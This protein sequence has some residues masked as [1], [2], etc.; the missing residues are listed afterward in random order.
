M[1]R[2]F[3]IISLFSLSVLP[4]QTQKI[5]APVTI[6]GVVGIPRAISS[7]QFRTCFAGVY[8]A[9][10]SVNARLFRNFFVGLGYQNTGFRNAEMFKYELFNAKVPY[11]TQLMGHAPFLKLGYDQ[12]FEKTYVSYSLNTGFMLAGYTNVNNDTSAANRPFVSQKFSAPY[13]QPEIALNFLADR[14]LNFSIILSYTTLFYKYDARAP[15]FAAFG[16]VAEKKNRYFMGWLN[17][18]FGVNILLGKH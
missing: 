2:F 6:R 4:A 13:L 15:R 12:F 7:Q 16:D 14:S 17:I 5:N 11:K 1:R 10:L 18:G 9:N 3:L 8:E